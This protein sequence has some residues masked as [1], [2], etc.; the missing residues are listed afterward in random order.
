MP[1]PPPTALQPPRKRGGGNEVETSRGPPPG[2]FKRGLKGRPVRP[3]CAPQHGFDSPP[4]A[5]LFPP[6]EFPPPPS[7]NSPRLGARGWPLAAT[8][9]E[10]TYTARALWVYE[11]SINRPFLFF[12]SLSLVL[13]ET[14]GSTDAVR[15][16]TLI[17]L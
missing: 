14:V 8:K 17:Q 12:F 1:R 13:P 2:P 4:R 10:I 11:R 3:K 6:P 15:A 9:R 16:S 5:L 7:P